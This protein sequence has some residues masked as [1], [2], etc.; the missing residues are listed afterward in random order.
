M[1]GTIYLGITHFNEQATDIA[2]RYWLSHASKYPLFHQLGEFYSNFCYT[3]SQRILYQNASRLMKRLRSEALSHQQS[4]DQALFLALFQHDFQEVNAIASSANIDGCQTVDQLALSLGKRLPMHHPSRLS[5]NLAIEEN[6]SNLKKLSKR[7]MRT[8]VL[9]GYY[10]HPLGVINIVVSQPAAILI[11]GMA[12]FAPADLLRGI[13]SSVIGSAVASSILGYSLPHEA[14]H[15]YSSN[16]N[17]V[18]LIPYS[19]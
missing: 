1:K 6:D 15:F 12:T 7:I 2:T 11:G 3:V 13:S 8:M 9:G 10:D 17:Y 18:G 5:G 16:S 19:A 14:I 4:F